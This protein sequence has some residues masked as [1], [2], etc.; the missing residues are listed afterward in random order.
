[1]LRLISLGYWR[2]TRTNLTFI[3]DVVTV[4]RLFCTFNSEISR[5]SFILLTTVRSWDIIRTLLME[6]ISESAVTL[7]RARLQ[8][9]YSGLTQPFDVYASHALY[10]YRTMSAKTPSQPWLIETT[11]LVLVLTGCATRR[12]GDPLIVVVLF[13]PQ[14]NA[15]PRLHHYLWLRIRGVGPWP[16]SQVPLCARTSLMLVTSLFMRRNGAAQSIYV[17]WHLQ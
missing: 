9:A 15:N 4:I 10:S 7:L 12:C 2:R 11:F 17:Y 14:Q 1:M 16:I 8:I 3:F 5:A 6:D 13:L